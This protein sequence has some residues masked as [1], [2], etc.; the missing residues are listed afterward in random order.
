MS[1]LA[2]EVRINGKHKYTVG[3][4]NWLHLS[5]F[6]SAHLVDPARFPPLPDEEVSDPIAEPMVHLH[7]GSSVVIADEDVEVTDPD[8]HVRTEHRSG[9]YE[10]P[11]IA[12]GDVIEIRIITTDEATDP[13]WENPNNRGGPAIVPVRSDD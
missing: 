6:L 10:V 13:Q 8:G 4:E 11:K 9:H 7:L 3:A 12:E 1:F 5:T 2:F